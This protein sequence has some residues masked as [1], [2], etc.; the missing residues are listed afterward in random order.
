M[1][2]VCFVYF[3]IVSFMHVPVLNLCAKD[4]TLCDWIWVQIPLYKRNPCSHKTRNRS[5]DFTALEKWYRLVVPDFP[6]LIFT[7]ICCSY[8]DWFQLTLPYFCAAAAYAFQLSKTEN[9]L[10]SYTAYMIDFLF[11]FFLFRPNIQ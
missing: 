4:S 7:L 1:F 3:T 6:F 9:T 10:F 8:F 5:S 11:H 2:E